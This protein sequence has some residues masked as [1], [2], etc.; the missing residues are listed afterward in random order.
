[1]FSRVYV[2]YY[3]REPDFELNIN[4]RRQFSIY[5]VAEGELNVINS[6]KFFTLKAGEYYIF[7]PSTTQKIR[8]RSDAPVKYY[9][10]GFYFNNEALTLEDISVSES[11]SFSKSSDVTNL[12]ATLYSSYSND[13][14]DLSFRTCYLFYKVMHYIFT[15]DND[16]TLHSNDYHKLKPVIQYINENY[17]QELKIETLCKICNYSQAHLQRLFNKYFQISTKE[18]ISRLRISKAQRL[19]VELDISVNK[20][21]HMVGYKDIGFFCRTFKKKTGC[22]PTEFRRLHLNDYS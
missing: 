3:V 22:T 21:A 2:S 15:N 14:D 20:V 13:I 10:I 7:S 18:Y 6:G 1:M 8:N 5:Y 9:V 4:I 11:G 12:F 19:M 16:I 17:S